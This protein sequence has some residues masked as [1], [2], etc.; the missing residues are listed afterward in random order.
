M[1]N[2]GPNREVRATHSRASIKPPTRRARVARPATEKLAVP[3]VRAPVIFF[4]SVA[5]FAA[6]SRLIEQKGAAS[7]GALI[8]AERLSLDVDVRL[9]TGA[10]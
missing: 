3:A 8:W 9:G 4:Q 6:N 10:I 7:M 2:R 1:R 5:L